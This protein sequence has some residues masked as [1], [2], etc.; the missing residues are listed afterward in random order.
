M[1]SNWDAFYG[2]AGLR[3]VVNVSGTM[4]S[5]GASIAVP[6]AV[7]AVAAILPR[8]VQM[9]ELHAR[10]SRAVA[11]AT[12]AEA[13]FITAS[14]SAGI[15]LAV[16]A[17]IVHTFNYKRDFHIPADEVTRCENART[18]ALAGALA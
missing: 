5:L 7:E 11:A 15:T 9:G 18:Q 3:P 8:F 12:G 2:A 6:E 1:A 10:A 16:A 13:G 14:A 17:A 4:T